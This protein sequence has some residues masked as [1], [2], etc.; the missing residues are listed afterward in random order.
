M[1]SRAGL[2]GVGAAN[3]SDRLAHSS[4]GFGSLTPTEQG[5][6]ALVVNCRLA[7][8]AS[9]GSMTAPHVPA[10]IVHANSAGRTGSVTRN[11]RAGTSN[12]NSHKSAAHQ[13]RPACEKVRHD[14]FLLWANT[15]QTLSGYAERGR[16][17]P[18]SF[19]A[20]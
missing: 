5:H 16:H 4:Q 12:Q 15:A 19:S 8:A 11:C 1:G 13:Q 7:V 10:R 3:I 6:A 20:A 14:G 18:N 9:D 17:F 2:N